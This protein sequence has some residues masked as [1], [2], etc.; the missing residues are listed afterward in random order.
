[1][2]QLVFG[3]PSA[4]PLNGYFI[5]WLSG[6]NLTNGLPGQHPQHPPRPSTKALIS[7]TKTD[8]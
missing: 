2:A 6:S 4:Y 3:G 1:M 8:N 5:E 7:A